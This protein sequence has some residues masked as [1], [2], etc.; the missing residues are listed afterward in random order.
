MFVV[1]AVRG[2]SGACL[3]S[4]ALLSWCVFRF[5][6]IALVISVLPFAALGKDIRLRNELIRTPEKKQAAAAAAASDERPSEGLFLIQFDNPIT[7]AQR[8]ELLRLNVELLQPVPEDAFVARVSGTRLGALRRLSYVHWVGPLRAEHKVHQKLSGLKEKRAVSFLIA[9]NARATEVAFLK[10][11][12]AGVQS[13]QAT[14]AGTVL[15]GYVDAKQLEAL[16]QSPAVLWIEPASK[17]KLFDEMSAEIIEGELEEP[18]AYIPSLGFTGKGVTVSV[19][20][21]GLMEGTTAGMHPDLAGRVDAFFH[22]GQLDSAADEH[23]HGT[24]VSGI[25]AGNGATGEMD[26]FGYLYGLGVAPEAHLVTQRLFDGLGGYEAPESFEQL[27]RDAVQAGAIIGSNS[28]GD[29]TQGQ[30]DLSAMEFDGLVRD[31]DAQTPGDQPYILEF[32]AGNAGP[33]EQTIG[34]PA[35]GKNVIATGAAQNNRFDFIIY[36]EGQDA[37]ADFSSRG[38]CAD[39]RIK[40]DV[41]APG[42][43]IASLQSSAATDESAWLSISPNYQYQG[44]TSQSGPHVSGAAAVFVQYYRETHNGATPSPALVKAALINS[45]VDMDSEFGTAAIPNN[46]EGWGRVDL[47]ELIGSDKTFEFVDQTTPLIQGQVY[48]KNVYVADDSLPLR[49]SLVYTDVPGTPLVI[50]ALVNDLD[51][52]VIGPDGVIYAGN[53]MIDGESAPQPA[54]RDSLNNVEG[55]YLN[56]P[57]SGEYTVRIRARRVAQDARRDTA[58][59]DQ[60]FALVVSGSLPAAGH[61]VVAFD[62]R[63]YTAPSTIGLKL[64]DFDLAGQ[65]EALVTLS[66]TTEAAPLSVRLVPSGSVG[67]FTGAVATAT[68][69]AVSDATLQI[70]HND[71]ITARYQDTVPLETVETTRRADLLSPVISNVTAVNRFGNELVSWTTDEAAAGVVFYG[72]A[73]NLNQAVTNFTYRAGQAVSLTNLVAG[74]TYQFIVISIDE[75][76]NRSTNDNS[77]Q[78]Y[79]FV[80]QPASTVL[81]VDAY[82]HGPDDESEFIPVTSYTDALAGTGVSYE[83]WNVATDGQPQLS[84]LIPFRVVMWRINDSFYDSASLSI[85]QQTMIEQY[86]KRDGAFMLASMEILTRLGD[87]AFRTNVLGVAEFTYP[88]DPFA[89][90]P[91]CDQDHGMP[92]LEGLPA[93]SIGAGVLVP[94]NYD[95]YPVFELEP[96]FPDIGPDFSDTFTA[97]TNA[98][99]IFVDADSGRVTGVRLPRNSSKAPGRVVFLAFPLDGIPMTGDAPNNRV[100]ILRN[101]LAYL[102]PG[103][104]GLGTLSFDRQ[105]YSIPDRVTIEVADSDLAGQGTAAARISSDTDAAGVPVTLVETPKKGVFNGSVTLVATTAAPK[106]GELRAAD[107]DGL[108]AEYFDASAN[109]TVT[110]HAEVD[111][112]APTISNT[113][114]TPDYEYA[115]ITWS[116]DE[117]ADSLVQYGESKFLG[118]TVYRSAEDFDHE[119][120]I[121][122]LQPGQAYYYQVVSRD[123][124]GNTVVDDNG[125]NFYTLQM[126]TPKTVPWSDNMEAA[127]TDWTVENTEDSEFGWQLG[128]PTNGIETAGHSGTK[129]WG[130]NLD[131]V[132]GSY[133]ES[134]L[135]SPAFLLTGGNRATLTFWHSYDFSVDATIQSASLNIVTNS[136]A[137]AVTLA[138][139]DGVSGSWEQEEIDLTP[140]IGKVVQL[141]WFYQLFDVEEAGEPHR[142][143]LV[144]DVAISMA[145]ENRGS[146][147]VRANL[148]Q[149]TYTI[150]GPSPA[151]GQSFGYTNSAALSGTYTI[152]WDPVP[153]YTTPATQTV[154]L[155]PGA[156]LV[157][158]GKYDFADVNNNDIS[159]QWETTY[160]GSASTPHDGSIDSDADGATDAAEFAAG[161]SPTD[162][163]SVLEFEN[164]AVLVDGRV[165]LSWPAASGYSY[166][167]MGSTDARTWTPYTSWTRSNTTRMVQTLPALAPGVGYFFQVEVKP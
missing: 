50:P 29:D 48:E 94:M 67:V 157:I 54:G 38:P 148:S 137:N 99:P 132:M 28:W 33:G 23:S 85:A 138:A 12:I 30:Y 87:S 25:V 149:A 64:I 130:S 161:T 31:A 70:A 78:R 79:S 154:T 113:A 75:A 90:C 41:V 4:R 97:S 104:N 128:T 24:H 45:A 139:Y 123:A 100:N 52:E 68:G 106:A 143:W 19:A 9:P 121:Q 58:A 107:A 112:V 141:V 21:S 162:A 42:T 153:N 134:A 5:L 120:I 119:L 13:S 77:G 88:T 47:T 84:D 110:V 66:S 146:L 89:D 156:S 61:A 124:A 163:A 145:T 91:E 105:A 131:G 65:P 26:E 8:E 55:V 14:M 1:A 165:Q 10:K 34:S 46:D 49:F 144:D 98:V 11:R 166:R 133:S 129:A 147:I 76:G 37:M 73:G 83:V 80:A 35:V 32:S 158:E 43:W 142:G 101:I 164:P 15:H 51:L 63:A 160:F 93:D 6:R 122:A 115:I 81:L 114:A 159:D 22:Y 7:D 126:R 71:T 62:R 60:D 167:V 111:A 27:T 20:D 82:T 3:A 40:P 17:P 74:Q 96:I 135:I 57:V 152:T 102:A 44:G 109:S 136:Q 36:A 92:T 155:A 140:Y 95:S 125:G 116:T 86:L 53:Q 69:P 117:P 103:V 108:I 16:S 56:T 59:T 2:D 39:G 118:K 151:I 18:G 150:D 127:A 72:A